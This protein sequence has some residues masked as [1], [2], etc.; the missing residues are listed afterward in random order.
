MIVA[1]WEGHT[2]TLV[3]EAQ[4]DGS[5]RVHGFGIDRTLAWAERDVAWWAGWVASTRF[6]PPLKRIL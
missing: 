3:V 4:E 1:E 2:D 5:Y 6:T